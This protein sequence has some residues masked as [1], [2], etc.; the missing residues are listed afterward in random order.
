M[1]LEKKLSKLCMKTIIPLALLMTSFLFG[2]KVACVG[3]SLTHTS[4]PTFGVP[5]AT[6]IKSNQNSYWNTQ[7]F[8]DVKNWNPDYVMLLL[9]TND[10]APSNW[11]SSVAIE[12]GNDYRDFLTNFGGRFYLGII[13]YVMP[14]AVK[15]ERNQN[16]DQ[17]N[18]IIRQIALEKGLTVLEF[19]K[20]LKPEHYWSDGIHLN[21]DGQKIMANVAYNEL[22]KTVVVIPPKTIEDMI[23]IATY[24]ETQQ[25]IDLDWTDVPQTGNYRLHKSWSE[26]RVLQPPW[27][28]DFYDK[29]PVFIKYPKTKVKFVK[30]LDTSKTDPTGKGRE[31]VDAANEII[32]LLRERHTAFLSAPTGFGKTCLGS[33]FIAEFKLKTVV[34]THSVLVKDQWKDE[35][36]LFTNAK[37]QIVKGNKPL[38]PDVDV[39]IIGVIKS[40]NMD[41]YNF[42]NIGMVIIDEAHIAT[43]TI[44]SKSLLKFEPKYLI[45]LSATPDRNDGLH[46]LLYIYFGPKKYFVEKKETKNFTVVKYN[47][48]YKP[49]ISYRVIRGKTKI[50]WNKIRSSLE[51]NK[52]RQ[53]ELAQIAIDHPNDKFLILSFLKKQSNGIYNILEKKDEDVELLIG[54]KKT[55]NKEAR[56]LIAGMKKAGEGFNDPNLTMEILASDTKDVRQYEGRLRTTNCVIWDPVDDYIT[57]EKHWE[58]RKKWYLERGATI[59]HKGVQREEKSKELTS[60]KRFL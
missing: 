34:I 17:A 54:N 27:W 18:S 30:K 41:R 3:N 32:K 51:C 25:A 23:L 19:G 7:E 10:T 40:R 55:W 5:G 45:G 21:S 12:F 50:D 38:D 49:E 39:Y 43:S 58:I 42:T 16:V 46:K 28:K 56:I 15:V 22:K 14:Y 1:G 9:A 60:Y 59:I 24:N 53:A 11:N 35:I 20:A 36:E 4:Y 33:Y 48:S 8:T 13:P 2:Q 26:G 37:V 44:F 6:M 57:L 52:D 31:Q 47:T 29:F